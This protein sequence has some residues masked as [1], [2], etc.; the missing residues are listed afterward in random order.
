MSYNEPEP[1]N[2]A[3]RKFPDG[4]VIAFISGYPCNHGM[5]MSYMH[6]GQHGEALRELQEELEAIPAAEYADLLSELTSIGYAVTVVDR[7]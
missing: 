3:F 1:V 6:F 5:V 7:I 2:V 4:D